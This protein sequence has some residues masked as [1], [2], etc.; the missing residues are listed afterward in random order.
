MA[1]FPSGMSDERLAEI[2]ERLDD[3]PPFIALAGSN[4]RFTPVASYL[5]LLRGDQIALV[6]RP[7][8]GLLGGMLGLPT[9]EWRTKAWATADAL[10]A[11]PALASWRLVGEIEHTFTHFALTLDVYRAEGGAD[12]PD[13]IWLPIERALAEMPSVFGKGLRLAL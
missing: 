6:T 3:L 1:E 10:A 12:D 9:T 8:R 11:A 5:R 4:Q 2:R 13:L 7:P